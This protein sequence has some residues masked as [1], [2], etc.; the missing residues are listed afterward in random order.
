VRAVGNLLD[1]IYDVLFCPS[2]ALRRIGEESRWGMAVL[3]YLVCLIL[4]AIAMGFFIKTLGFHKFGGMLVAAEV[5]G[6]FMLLVLGVAV[7]HLVAELFGGKGTAKGLLAAM[8]FAH[9]PQL[10]A[11]PF[12]V[13]SMLWASSFWKALVPLVSVAV[14]C[15]TLVLNIVAIKEV[16]QISGGRAVLIFV[17]PIIAVLAMTVGLLIL[18][19]A[20]FIPENAGW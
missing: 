8:C 20:E 2:P 7:L 1:S 19:V 13:I 11:V 12:F 18:S 9:L 16:Y 14:S 6:R 10:L 15:W 4:P 3:V 17:I 5:V